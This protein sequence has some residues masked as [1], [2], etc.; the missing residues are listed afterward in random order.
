MPAPASGV[1]RISQAEY[2]DKRERVPSK[3]V[4]SVH[5]TRLREELQLHGFVTE[6]DKTR[7]YEAVVQKAVRVESFWT[8]AEAT[9][10]VEVR[11]VQSITKTMEGLNTEVT[12]AALRSRTE[13]PQLST[14]RQ[15]GG[16]RFRHLQ[17]WFVDRTTVEEV[18]VNAQRG[19]VRLHSGSQRCHKGQIIP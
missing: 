4:R 6:D 15:M 16:R 2:E 18:G 7:S 3:F 14:G 11:P 9:E 5:N 8:G 19:V 17:C 1:D 12:V 10:R 13:Y